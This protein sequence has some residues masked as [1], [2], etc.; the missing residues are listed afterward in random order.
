[1]IAFK[2]ELVLKKQA[3]YV[4]DDLNVPFICLFVLMVV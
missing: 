3:L 1:M 4:S 2:F